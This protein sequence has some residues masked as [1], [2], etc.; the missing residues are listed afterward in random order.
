MSS[1]DPRRSSRLPVPV[2]EA[3]RIGRCHP[4]KP[5]EVVVRNGE[6]ASRT[7][8]CAA[9]MLRN[10]DRN[11]LLLLLDLAASFVF[12]VE[13]ASA[14][15]GGRFD[16]LGVVVLSFA[17]ALG[18]GIVRDV[19]IGSLPAAAVRDWRYSAVAF[20]GGAV[21]FVFAPIV[22]QVPRALMIG[23]DAA[24]LALAAMAGAEKALAWKI[25]PFVAILLGGIT[26]VGGGTL[27][28][29]LMARSPSVLHSDIYAVAAMTGAAAMIA[30]QRAGLRP[31]RSTALGFVVCFVLR[32]AAVWRSWNLPQLP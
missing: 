18:G 19:L 31:S 14:A 24:G 32:A 6:P 9:N 26:G 17:T 29:I 25:H 2:S 28:D 15:A 1:D 10:H 30:A 3:A 22:Q 23:L 21:V 4:R 12:A 8:E 13:G 27:R 7:G 16:A 11:R 5:R 20:A